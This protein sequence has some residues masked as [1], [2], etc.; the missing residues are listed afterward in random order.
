[1]AAKSVMVAWRCQYFMPWRSTIWEISEFLHPAGLFQT[2]NRL[3][4]GILSLQFS[5]RILRCYTGLTRI[6]YALD[7][8]KWSVKSFYFCSKY[9][10]NCRRL[11]TI[12]SSDR[13]YTSKNRWVR[14]FI[15]DQIFFGVVGTGEKALETGRAWYGIGDSWSF[16]NVETTLSS[17][18]ECVHNP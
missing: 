12:T 18:I 17:P 5:I 16:A 4:N 3:W 13:R 9:F 7:I 10:M 2:S 8:F 6:P 14:S 15:K 1:M 11:L